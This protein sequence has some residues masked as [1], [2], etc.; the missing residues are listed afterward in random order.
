MTS[1]ISCAR[2]MSPLAS[3]YVMTLIPKTRHFFLNDENKNDLKLEIKPLPND[4]TMLDLAS[5]KPKEK[6]KETQ[7]IQRARAYQSQNS[8]S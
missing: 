1:R 3:K 4:L 2:N 8:I 5:G 6:D 7:G